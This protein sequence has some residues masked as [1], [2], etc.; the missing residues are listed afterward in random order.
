MNKAIVISGHGNFATGFKN[1][2]EFILG[3]QENL[4][5]FD[6]DDNDVEKLEK[7]YTDILKKYKKVI[8][9]TDIA[10]GT[11]FNTIALLEEK[12]S[13]FYLISGCNIPLVFSAIEN[14]EIKEIINEGINGITL[15]TVEKYSNNVAVENGI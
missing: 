6:F 15:Y 5:Y 2:L 7:N 12:Y 4:F 3:K 9:L 8:F 10:G 1:T 13:N 11:P 14:E